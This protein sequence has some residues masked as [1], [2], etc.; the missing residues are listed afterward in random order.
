MEC[1]SCRSWLKT[2]IVGTAV[3]K[4]Q[5]KAKLIEDLKDDDKYESWMAGN[6]NAAILADEDIKLRDATG[7][8]SE[9]CVGIFYPPVVYE[10]KFKEP[11]HK[12][13]IKLIPFPSGPQPGVIAEDDG[14]PLLPG[15]RRLFNYEDVSVAMG[16]TAASSKHW[17]SAEDAR[18]QFG[19]MRGKVARDLKA[20]ATKAADGKM[21]AI[22]GAA[23]P[24]VK[25]ARA[26]GK[27]QLQAKSSE[28]SSENWAHFNRPRSGGTPKKSA[29]KARISPKKKARFARVGKFASP[30]ASKKRPSPNQ[31]TWRDNAN[32]KR[33]VQALEQTS[34][35]IEHLQQNFADDECLPD[36]TTAKL[37]QIS[38]K[39]NDLLESDVWSYLG[40]NPSDLTEM[41]SGRQNLLGNDSKVNLI[42][43]VMVEHNNWKNKDSESVADPL[44]EEQG[45]D[46]KAFMDRINMLMLVKKCRDLGLEVA[47][48]IC[49][50]A[51]IRACK[52]AYEEELKAL[53][54]SETPP[55][56]P[57]LTLN[58]IA[59]GTEERLALRKEIIYNV[60]T[61]LAWDKQGD[62]SKLAKSANNCQACSGHLPEPLAI[63]LTTAEEFFSINF[64]TETSEQ[65]LTDLRARVVSSGWLMRSLSNQPLG[66]ACLAELDHCV[67]SLKKDTVYSRHLQT[68]QADLQSANVRSAL[69]SGSIETIVQAFLKLAKTY[70]GITGYADEQF[71]R[72]HAA[73]IEQVSKGI[74]QAGTAILKLEL[75]NVDSQ[76]AQLLQS[77]LAIQS[78]AVRP[79][80]AANAPQ[81]VQRYTEDL[82]KLVGRT[83]DE[84]GL[85]GIGSAE[86]LQRWREHVV[87]RGTFL[88]NISPACALLVRQ[89]TS[90]QGTCGVP[91]LTQDELADISG[92]M[93]L[94]KD[95]ATCEAVFTKRVLTAGVVSVA[96]SAP[97]AW[98]K[99]MQEV[100]A[101]TGGIVS[102]Q[103]LV[104]SRKD[105]WKKCEEAA[106]RFAATKG[107]TATEFVKKIT[108]GLDALV[109]ALPTS[110]VSE[111]SGALLLLDTLMRITDAAHSDDAALGSGTFRSTD[112]PLVF[113]IARIVLALVNLEGDGMNAEH[114]TEHIQSMEVQVSL[115]EHFIRS[116][117]PK[118]ITGLACEQTL[119]KLE[120]VKSYK[121]V[122]TD[123]VQQAGNTK[124]EP[125]VVDLVRRYNAKELKLKE[126]VQL[127]VVQR[128]ELDLEAAKAVRRC[129]L[130]QQLFQSV[131][132]LWAE[133][134]PVHA[135]LKALDLT[136]PLAPIPDQHRQSL[137]EV[138]NGVGLLSASQALTKKL[139]Q[140]ETRASVVS[141]T[142][143]FYEV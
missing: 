105:G 107:E 34:Q 45:P 20:T 137:K 87:L 112:M 111:I 37:T 106:G 43:H 41:A 52:G 65:R 142:R 77:L 122:L 8:R 58:E 23:S 31:G 80:N 4:K 126:L 84:I 68:L 93:E 2:H 59:T 72:R 75:K 99:A 26:S 11:P 115:A 138:L 3:Q 62:R 96:E 97:A 63:E 132:K 86:T 19:E 56:Y 32:K 71:K 139:K 98:R 67:R 124:L 135:A 28:E 78:E 100:K 133:R 57:E 7:F 134:E 128:G 129:E 81:I 95:S 54:N 143:G 130:G 15:C 88:S 82:K 10:T 40:T 64:D 117:D 29:A 55:G 116:R 24:V 94:Y 33:K 22:S 42:M 79:E 47:P 85:S 90:D 121:A 92:E 13:M 74:D 123:R 104:L 89:A 73:A 103:L 38:K 30:K 12:D 118:P 35:D 69:E 39:I 102:Q 119:S 51:F 25:R 5:K 83:S 27:K 50:Q 61:D 127:V 125:I 141:S 120:V 1:G 48:A 110:V 46:T 6:R 9:E 114:I 16:K 108:T 36:I 49:K 140:G 21:S 109:Q 18:H 14:L 136:D 66:V 131:S 53:L 101:A 44:A 91:P 76:I 113:Q 17:D 70:A 60:M